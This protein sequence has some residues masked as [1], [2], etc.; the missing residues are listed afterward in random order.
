MSQSDPT[1]A[2]G[3][4]ASSEDSL[5]TFIEDMNIRQQPVTF[6]RSE[7]DDLAE[8]TD[9]P[10]IAAVPLSKLGKKA[11]KSAKAPL[12]AKAALENNTRMIGALM[13]FI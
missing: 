1:A 4:L 10:G 11:L 5:P 7:L 13:E 6:S 3:S 2:S 12:S 8:P 9:T